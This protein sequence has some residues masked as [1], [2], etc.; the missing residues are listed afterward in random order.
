MKKAALCLF[1]FF[2][3]S[4]TLKS[5][6]QIPQ[7][8]LTEY[9]AGFNQPSDIETAGDNR[10]FVSEL[11]GKIKIIQNGIVHPTPFLDISMTGASIYSFCF[12]PNYSSNGIFFVYYRK[13]DGLGQI[14]MFKRNPSNPNITLAGSEAKILTLPYLVP[15]GHT[16]GEIAFGPDGYLYIT[17]GDDGLGTRKTMGDSPGNAQNLKT[18]L[19]KVL[20]IDVSTAPN[21]K[22]PTTNPYQT[23]GDSIP[24]E[25]WARGLRNPW[26][27]SFDKQTGDLWIGD[28]GA[29]HWDE[30][31]FL[32]HPNLGGANFGWRCY[33]GSHPY[34][35]N[36]CSDTT[37]L[38]YP[39]QEYQ[40]WVS[41]TTSGASVM[42][43][44]V[45]RGNLYPALRG[46][47]LYA[48]WVMGKLWTLFRSPNGQR[49]NTFQGILT[50]SPVTFGQDTS[51]ELYVASLDE[52]KIYQIGL[53]STLSTPTINVAAV[54]ASCGLKGQSVNKDAKLTIQGNTVTDR[55]DFTF[56]INYT[57]TA[58]YTAGSK[59]IPSNGV[60]VADLPNPI[61]P[62]TITVRIF[63]TTNSHIDITTTL[64]STT[65]IPCQFPAPQPQ[66][67]DTIA[68]VGTILNISVKGCN[69]LYTLKVFSDSLLT[70]SSSLTVN[71]NFITT[72][73][74]TNPLKVYTA[75]VHTTYPECKSNYALLSVRTHSVPA[76]LTALNITNTSFAIRWLASKNESYLLKYRVKNTASDWITLPV[77][78][79]DSTGIFS[80]ILSS[81]SQA[82]IYE[83]TVS[84]VHCHNFTIQETRTLSCP[85][86]IT[87]LVG[88]IAPST[89]QA[90]EVI[91]SKG[92]L[93]SGST[94]FYAGKTIILAPGFQSAAS[95]TFSA[96]IKGCD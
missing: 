58:S 28:N 76:A 20:R 67:I 19:G 52:G 4:Y 95:S 12:S 57:G 39:I 10:L 59:T 71:N 93:L 37:L 46:H 84:N 92:T 26:R 15:G 42:G 24:D 90:H 16:G 86:T 74:L 72:P 78:T 34:S 29:D 64:A 45:Y 79:A 85:P 1:L 32:A 9:A 56:G 36:G 94:S 96:Q 18:V 63:S 7:I 55:Y 31:N 61:S 43:G 33:E 73:T 50:S 47:Y 91:Q 77:L 17:T 80:T 49:T 23:L 89:Y 54:P 35:S 11:T 30:V 22:I 13:Q 48:D 6:N 2:L 44:Y 88:P 38:I 69:G 81:L 53:K 82:T 83:W 25:I 21:Y 60:L 27:M 62:Q 75:C 5:Q 14:V 87:Q 51:G 8:Q 66:S 40:G 65:C 41:D 68:C 3:F 70:Q